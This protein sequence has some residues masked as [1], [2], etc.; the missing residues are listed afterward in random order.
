MKTIVFQNLHEASDTTVVILLAIFI[1][2]SL[3]INNALVDVSG[4]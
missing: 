3:S 2:S 4:F 1:L